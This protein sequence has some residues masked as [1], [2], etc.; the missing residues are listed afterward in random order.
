MALLAG[1]NKD[2]AQS[3]PPKITRR[4]GA[5]VWRMEFCSSSVCRMRAEQCEEMT[6]IQKTAA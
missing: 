1:I 2:E 4:A 3:D 5:S 6:K